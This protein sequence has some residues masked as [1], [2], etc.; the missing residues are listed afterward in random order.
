MD[1]TYKYEKDVE[2]D[3]LEIKFEYKAIR[4]VKSIENE[5]VPCRT[6]PQNVQES[7]PTHQSHLLPQHQK[8]RIWVQPQVRCQCL[9]VRARLHHPRCIYFYIQANNIIN[10]YKEAADKANKNDELEK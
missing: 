10:K 9:W 4:I 7:G 1:L 8:W 5:R 6:A 3:G 2:W